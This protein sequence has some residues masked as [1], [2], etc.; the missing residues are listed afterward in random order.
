MRTTI[1]IDNAL[2]AEAQKAFGHTTK[3]AMIEQALGV[4]IRLRGQREVDAF[5]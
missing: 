3:K 1:E 5:R 2:M 4:M